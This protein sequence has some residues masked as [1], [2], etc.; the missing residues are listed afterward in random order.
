MRSRNQGRGRGRVPGAES[1]G[2][3]WASPQGNRSGSGVCQQL[4]LNFH[5]FCV[6][7]TLGEGMDS[8][9]LKFPQDAALHLFEKLQ[10]YIS[11]LFLLFGFYLKWSISSSPCWV[12]KKV[13]LWDFFQLLIFLLAISECSLHYLISLKPFML[14]FPS[15]MKLV[16]GSL[17]SII[18]SCHCQSLSHKKYFRNL[19]WNNFLILSVGTEVI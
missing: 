11:P 17:A 4:G 15:I 3:A 13:V 10:F 5:V 12:C 18:L 14:E 19:F 7:R 2:P 6:V 16:I 9:K 8:K 1:W